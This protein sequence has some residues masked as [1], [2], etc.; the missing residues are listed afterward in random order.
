MH[1]VDGVLVLGKQDCP[2]CSHQTTPGTVPGYRTCSGCGGTGQGPRGGKNGCPKCHGYR[3]TFALGTVLTDGFTI[4]Q[5]YY[6]GA[7]YGERCVEPDFENRWPCPSCKGDYEESAD[8]D[9]NDN[10]GPDVR[11]YLKALPIVYSKPEA[12]A[13]T[14]MESYIGV[15]FYSCEDYGRWRDRPLEELEQSVRDHMDGWLQASKFTRKSDM[16][17]ATAIGISLRTNGYSVFGVIDGKVV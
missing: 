15:G 8:E 1:I 13:S 11:E 17:V 4:T 12:R 3:H 16:R 7:E 6:R 10:P 14:F 9:I 5:P 2:N